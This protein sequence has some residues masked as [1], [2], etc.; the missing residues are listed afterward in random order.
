MK[1]LLLVVA[2]LL[3]VAILHCDSGKTVVVSESGIDSETACSSHAGNLNCSNL[4]L[5]LEGV[6]SN[7]T[8]AIE[9]GNYTLRCSAQHKFNKI[10]NVTISGTSRS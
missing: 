3:H 5:A 8:I 2:A 9:R 1:Q 7:T 10:K 6:V 4:T